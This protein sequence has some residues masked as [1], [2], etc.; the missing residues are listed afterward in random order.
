MGGFWDQGDQYGIHG[1]ADSGM[2]VALTRY[3]VRA[4]RFRSSY[5]SWGGLSGTKNADQW[6]VPTLWM[7]NLVVVPWW[8]KVSNLGC[9]KR[10]D[11][12]RAPHPC[13]AQRVS[14]GSGRSGQWL[15]LGGH[16][17]GNRGLSVLSV[18]DCWTRCSRFSSNYQKVLL[19]RG[20][21]GMDNLLKDSLWEL[22]RPHFSP[23]VVVQLCVTARCWNIGENC[24]P[25][26]AFLLSLSRLDRRGEDSSDMVTHRKKNMHR[27][28]RSNAATDGWC[29]DWACVTPAPKTISVQHICE[30][31]ED[32]T[33]SSEHHD[34]LAS[35][36][37]MRNT[38]LVQKD[39]D[40]I[41]SA[42]SDSLSPDMGEVALC[43]NSW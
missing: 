26:G 8:L 5:R 43:N 2:G 28:W 25:F 9:R 36:V 3:V 40:D 16:V 7:L 22:V 42:S 37:G 35:T 23:D 41:N 32:D 12:D 15:S 11:C 1:F 13:L 38:V 39:F 17:C 14:C 10:T 27:D 19:Y 18:H 6:E 24:G 34:K 21:R 33:V 30:D 29:A 31:H 20:W 4:L